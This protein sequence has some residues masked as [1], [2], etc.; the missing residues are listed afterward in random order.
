MDEIKIKIVGGKKLKTL[1]VSGRLTSE[2]DDFFFD[3]YNALVD[4][5]VSKLLI[6]FNKV[7]YINSAGMAVMLVMAKEAQDK[8]IKLVFTGLTTHFKKVAE[9]IHM[10]KIVDIIDNRD[11][12]INSFKKNKN[13]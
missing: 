12:A 11:E 9:M 5:N 8:G 3:E 2:N 13:N 1:E 7:T 10:D 6:D 4:N